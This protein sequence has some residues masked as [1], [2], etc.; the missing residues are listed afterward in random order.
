MGRK[1]VIIA[2]TKPPM[3]EMPSSA[4]G[5]SPL[6]VARHAQSAVADRIASSKNVLPTV[7]CTVIVVLRGTT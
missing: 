5:K 4:I 7:P 1:I 6:P 3:A 2:T